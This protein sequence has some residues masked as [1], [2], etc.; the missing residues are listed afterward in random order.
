MTNTA[1]FGWTKPTVSGSTD[2]W[3][4]ILNAVFDA[5]DAEVFAPDI[6]NSTNGAA[7]HRITNP[8]TGTG[9]YAQFTLGN[10]APHIWTAAL[11]GVNYTQ[12]VTYDYQDGMYQVCDGTGGMN[13]VV[14]NASGVIRWF[15][16]TGAN[17]PERMRISAAGLVGIGT[18]A[19]AYQVDVSKIAAG[20]NATTTV[21]VA[22]PNAGTSAGTAYRQYNGT[23]TYGSTFTGASYT[24][25]TTY[26]FADGV[27]H[28]TDG[29]GGLNFAANNGP[30]RW[31]CAS[32][33]SPAESM[34]LD[35]GGELL[36]G[37]TTDNG[38]YLLQVNS[39]IFATNATIAT[40][41]ARVKRQ[42]PDLSLKELDAISKI[43]IRMYERI[44]RLEDGSRAGYF[45]QDWQAIFGLETGIVKQ[46]NEKAMLQLDEGAAHALKIAALEY[47]LTKALGRIEQL[48]ARVE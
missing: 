5:V 2:T 12:G 15:T 33:A 3:G 40:S 39:Q 20:E 14:N 8:N 44:D 10:S 35:T 1:N 16:G 19:P 43:S 47:Q 36:I 24:P 13:F 45:A 18:I 27:Y 37:T 34:R 42:L 26:D 9:A 30:I 46:P 7:L 48:E 11:T 4:T 6:S 21:N 32:G 31:F 17:P 25:T 22:N 28:I 38:A 41:D 29:A 23:H